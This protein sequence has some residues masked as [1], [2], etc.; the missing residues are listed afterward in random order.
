VKK[1]DPA[2]LALLG[3]TATDLAVSGPRVLTPEV[4]FPGALRFTAF[5]RNGSAEPAPAA[6]DYVIHH[7]RANGTV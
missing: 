4:T 7:R 3:Y 2:A 1:G 5:V 6:I